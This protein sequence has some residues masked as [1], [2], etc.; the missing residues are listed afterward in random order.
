MGKCCVCP[1]TV[2]SQATPL[3]CYG[4][5]VNQQCATEICWF[6]KLTVAAMREVNIMK[7]NY[8]MH[9]GWFMGSCS[10]IIPTMK[11][12]QSH[13]GNTSKPAILSCALLIYDFTTTPQW[14]RPNWASSTSRGRDGGRRETTHYMIELTAH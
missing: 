1:V 6:F 4:E 13:C 3:T 8:L 14:G 7:L 5:V 10:F 11:W 2:T 9:N 12:T